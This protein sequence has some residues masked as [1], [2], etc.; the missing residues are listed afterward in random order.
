M[1]PPP[2]WLRPVREAPATLAPG[3]PAGHAA[4][5]PVRAGL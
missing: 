4:G 2:S 1:R 3:P 5:G